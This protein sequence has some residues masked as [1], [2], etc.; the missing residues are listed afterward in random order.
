MKYGYCH[1]GSFG[2]KMLTRSRFAF[3]AAARVM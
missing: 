2:G 3:V 1:R